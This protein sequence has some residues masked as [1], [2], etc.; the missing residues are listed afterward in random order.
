[1]RQIQIHDN[2]SESDHVAK[3]QA[4][5]QIPL[6]AGRAAYA[7]T[8]E[9]RSDCGWSQRWPMLAMRNNGRCANGVHGVQR[10][11]YCH[12]LRGWQRGDAAR[13]GTAACRTAMIT[14]HPAIRAARSRGLL[15]R[16]M[17]MVAIARRRRRMMMGLRFPRMRRQWPGGQRRRAEQAQQE[18]QRG[19]DATGLQP[20]AQRSNHAP[21]LLRLRPALKLTRASPRSC[22]RLLPA[23]SLNPGQT[24]F[25]TPPTA[26]LYIRIPTRVRAP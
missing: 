17:T 7:E 6:R 15:G 3:R 25:A 9:E 14:T 24:R 4:A 8:N 1:M 20:M 11:D 2:L 16:R 22:K 19:E 5:A 23:S 10:S 26:R 21:S 13:G 18:P 12:P